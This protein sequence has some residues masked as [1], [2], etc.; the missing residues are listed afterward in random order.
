MHAPKTFIYNI[1]TAPGEPKLKQ[2]YCHTCIKNEKISNVMDVK[3]RE[4]A[5][6]I[7]CFTLIKVD[8]YM[9][10]N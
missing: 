10:T 1:R 3:N 7:G 2:L 9:A 5:Y 4:K 6:N 8:K